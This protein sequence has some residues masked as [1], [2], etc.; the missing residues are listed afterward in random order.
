MLLQ[1]TRVQFPELTLGSPQPPATLESVDLMTYISQTLPV[2][3]YVHIHTHQYKYMDKINLKSMH[4]EIIQIKSYQYYSSSYSLPPGNTRK[5]LMP[6]I[7]PCK[8][9]LSDFPWH[10]TSINLGKG[11]HLLTLL[12][13]CPVIP[14][15]ITVLA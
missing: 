2:Y 5:C 7:S 3:M 10:C 13:I 9:L 12:C 1:R 8:S 4:V 14:P 6:V 11:L 15:T